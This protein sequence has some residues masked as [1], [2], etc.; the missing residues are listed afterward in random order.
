MLPNWSKVILAILLV[1]GQQEAFAAGAAGHV[2]GVGDLL[3]PAINFVLF[4]VAMWWLLRKP[5]NAGVAGRHERIKSELDRGLQLAN[6]ASQALSNAERRRTELP[7]TVESLR[8]T[9]DEE[10]RNEST[11]IMNEAEARAEHIMTQARNQVLAERRVA[12]QVV[13]TALAERVLEIATNKLKQQIDSATE[14]NLREH[15]LGHLGSLS[16]SLSQRAG[17]GTSNL[18]MH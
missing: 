13:R 18:V 2:P 4:V 12:E 6:Q 10:A 14:S 11:R 9:I 15:L 1:L 17:D 3:Y 8:T 5:I 16:Q 7:K